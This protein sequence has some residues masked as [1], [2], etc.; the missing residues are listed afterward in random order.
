[1]AAYRRVYDSH[2][3]QADCQERDQLR[4]PTRGNRVWATFTFYQ[5][6]KFSRRSLIVWGVEYCGIARITGDGLVVRSRDGRC[7]DA[8][9]ANQAG[10]TRRSLPRHEV[11]A[12]RAPDHVP[13]L[14]TGARCV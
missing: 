2:H 7:R 13:R 11:H 4:N 3:L 1:M 10:R 6:V 5:I 9:G 8:R 12:E 14:Q